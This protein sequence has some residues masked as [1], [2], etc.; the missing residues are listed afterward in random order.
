MSEFKHPPVAHRRY[1]AILAVLY[2]LLGIVLGVDPY[3]RHTWTLEHV[4]VAVGFFVLL[5]SYRAF[6]LSRLSYTLIFVFLC[7]HEIGTHFNYSRVPY[8]EW[9]SMLTGNSLNDLLSLERN[10][11]DRAIHFLYGLL[12]AWPYREAFLHA[13]RSNPPP[14][15]SYLLPLTFTTSTSVVYE[16]VEWAAVLVYGGELGKAFLGVQGDE[17]DSHSDTLCAIAGALSAT[18]IM[19]AIHGGTRRDFPAEWAEQ[20]TRTREEA[21]DP[22]DCK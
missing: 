3:D 22:E 17:W 1:V 15:W 18:L 16:F 9:F 12:L 7:F 20:H 5:L 19:V 13:V 21:S 11:Y 8:N 10:H 6:P 4:M 2:L 14:F